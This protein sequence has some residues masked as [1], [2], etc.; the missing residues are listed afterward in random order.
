MPP[1]FKH[2]HKKNESIFKAEYVWFVVYV[3]MYLL[4]VCL[5]AFI[6]LPHHRDNIWKEYFQKD[7]K[8][9]E[10]IKNMKSQNRV[11]FP[12][13]YVNLD[14]SVNRHDRMQDEFSHL[15]MDDVH[16]VSG[17]DGQFITPEHGGNTIERGTVNGVKWYSE[18]SDQPYELACTLSHLKAVKTAYDDGCQYAFICEDDVSFKL[19]PFWDKSV[20]ELTKELNYLTEENGGWHILV[21]YNRH[22]ATYNP[23]QFLTF[24]KYCGTVAYVINREGMSE[25]LDKVWHEKNQEFRLTK[26]LP[27]PNSL[28]DMFI[29]LVT[30]KTFI[31]SKSLVYTH[32]TLSTIHNKHI[33]RHLSTSNRIIESYLEDL[34]TPDPTTKK[35]Q[36]R[37]K[38]KEKE[39]ADGDDDGDEAEV[40]DE[41]EDEDEKS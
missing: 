9:K 15:G 41:D 30:G 11:N 13:Y 3:G 31:Y 21:L 18:F 36:P 33:F 5:T 24:Q 19:M 25:L 35:N 28:A 34:L 32:S 29:Y 8:L 23:P 17:V 12:I 10:E 6:I 27:S 4:A 22:T 20:E 1:K 26:D 39:M 38:V 40:E 7:E 37:Q 16:R 2:A 14:R